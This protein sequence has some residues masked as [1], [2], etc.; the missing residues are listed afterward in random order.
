MSG[1]LEKLGV[2]DF[3]GIW[4]PGAIAV[5]YFWCTMRNTIQAVFNYLE[6]AIPINE[7]LYKLVILYS[8]VAYMIGVVL[9]ELG[10]IITERT[11]L[12]NITTVQHCSLCKFSHCSFGKKIREEYNDMVSGTIPNDVYASMTF[13][14]A[15]N[16]IKSNEKIPTKDIDKFHSVYGMSRSLL[17]C[18]LIHAIA[19][20]IACLF[21]GAEVITIRVNLTYFLIDIVL[22]VFFFNRAYR[23]FCSWV[24]TVFIQAYSAKEKV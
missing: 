23:Y 12:F 5:T 9:H 2:Y 10:K 7:E 6:I 13:H 4:G 8:A 15:V 20:L 18:F 11:K 1:A 24:R 21:G 17:L 16:K 22:S 14:K 3:M 19:K